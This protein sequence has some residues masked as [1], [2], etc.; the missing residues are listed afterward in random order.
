IL[1]QVVAVRLRDARPRHPDPKKWLIQVQQPPPVVIVGRPGKPLQQADGGFHERSPMGS[2]YWFGHRADCAALLC[3]SGTSLRRFRHRLVGFSAH[4]HE[5][6]R[7][8]VSGGPAPSKPAGTGLPIWPGRFEKPAHEQ[9][10]WL[11]AAVCSSP[12]TYGGYGLSFVSGRSG[13]R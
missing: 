6:T 1:A 2:P 12:E 3:L 4:R 7:F 10:A 13:K 8:T 11:L 9:A 5:A